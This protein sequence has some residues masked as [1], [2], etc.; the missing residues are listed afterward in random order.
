M[1]QKIIDSLLNNWPNIVGYI[2]TAILVFFSFFLIVKGLKHREGFIRYWFI[3]FGSILIAFLFL[4]VII[5]VT[6]NMGDALLSFATFGLA[7]A[8]GFLVNETRLA[9]NESKKQEEQYRKDQRKRENRETKERLLKEITS[10][11]LDLQETDSQIGDMRIH[12][13][14]DNTS[15][16]NSNAI[17][18]KLP[19]LYLN[20]LARS[21][22]VR[23][24][25][26]HEFEKEL[27]SEI[28]D[29]IDNLAMIAF[30]QFPENTK[31]QINNR[32]KGRALETIEKIKNS[33]NQYDPKLEDDLGK[34]ITQCWYKIGEIT[35]KF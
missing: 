18:L 1:W 11:L 33:E 5:T 17:I 20:L 22:Y 16:D 3:V 24:I 35:S 10:W 8:T 25:V 15:F 14:L 27:S 30:L 21:E 26:L 7:I 2:V 28:N 23:N 12:D 13:T 19:A 29:I 34:S 32:V 9:R 6:D 31:K 4:L